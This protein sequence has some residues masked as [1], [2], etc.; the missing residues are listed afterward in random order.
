[1][2]KKILYSFVFLGT[3]FAFAQNL[4]DDSNAAS[5]AN[6][7]DA[8]TGWAGT[9]NIFSDN[10]DVQSGNFSLRAVS[11]G[12]N[13][14]YVA[15][16]FDAVV[17]QDYNITIWARRGAQF[18]NPAF[19]N[20]QGMAGFSTTPIGTGVW[21]QY[22][23]T[24]TA[25][26]A[27]PQIRVYVSPWSARLVAGNTVFIDNITIVADGS[28]TE[29]PSAVTDLSSSN[30]TF[31][32]TDLSWSAST[33]NVGVTNYEVFQD[34][35]SIGNTG[36]T[37]FNVTG[38]AE[39]TS[40]DFT[41]FAQDAAGN[42]S[43]VSNTETVLTLQAPDTEAPSAIT[44]LASANTTTTTTDLSWS[45]STDNVG[46]TN[47]EVFQDGVSIANTGTTTAFNVT[48]L[49]PST[50]YDFTVFAEDAAGNVSTVSNTETVVT[51]GVPDTEAPSAVTDLSSANTTFNS[52]DL[53]WSSAIDNVGVTNYE[54]FQDGVSIGNTGTTTFNVTDL[55]ELTSYDFTVFAQDAAGN[56][57][58]VSNTET[59]VTLQAPD[60]E[61]PTSVSDLTSSNTT[62][63]TT[64]LT[65]SP[66]TDN[67]GVTNYEV[68]QD[69]FSIANTG[70][71][72]TLNVTG[73]TPSTSYDFT[74][75]AQDAAGNVSPVSNTETVSTQGVPDTE[76]P[77][78]VTD[79]SSSSTTSTSTS[80]SWSASTD[81]V[82][83]TNYEVFQDGVGIGNTGTNTTLNVT[84]LTPNTSYDFT[85]FAQDAA[86]NIS[87]VSNTETVVTLAGTGI[88][89]YTSENSNM[90]TVDWTARDLFA[91]RNLGIGTTDTQ[92]YRLAVAGNMIAE[93]VRVELQG[94]WPDYV[95]EPDFDLKALEEVK[96]FIEENGHLPNIPS[97]KQIEKEGIDL[98]TMNA[99]L[100]EKIEE[101]TL[102]LLAQD[103]K[104][105]QLELK[106]AKIEDLL[107]RIEQ[108]ERK[109]E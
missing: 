38:L 105:K 29:A 11:N 87:T 101:L 88:V 27:T 77:S 14:T 106:N 10:T 94:N 5:P 107:K 80:L 3:S 36:T 52:T 82:A 73:L 56:T 65:W 41:V 103:A 78:A 61:A 23:W 83:V 21:T 97:A 98:G 32:S 22:N 30:T 54:V 28:D 62:A 9:A 59:V 85:V 31:N 8:T 17:G 67:V 13:G 66:S 1:M 43:P 91:N 57:S 72:T 55:A 89:D 81:N 19:A 49:A 99:K 95:F 26:S 93:G 18:N 50:S 51:A 16:T 79:L 90:T 42:T 25:N 2:I 74:V 46:V 64:D 68:F 24:V 76:A 102:Y 58:L 12:N 53:S 108:L 86:S 35:V 47:Y 48:G 37:T 33:D 45:A 63:T 92:G 70:T 96:K 104:I 75:F 60:T 44:D 34:G 7:A 4:Y 100:L 84:G 6:E 69:G 109:Q 15:Y 20:W 71:A 39:L 40:Y